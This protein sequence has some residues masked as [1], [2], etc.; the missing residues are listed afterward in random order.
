MEVL[1]ELGDTGV[2]PLQTQHQEPQKG[3]DYPPDVSRR[4]L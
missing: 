2:T 4:S 1:K 3:E